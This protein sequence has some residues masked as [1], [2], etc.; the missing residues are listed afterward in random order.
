M[1]MLDFNAMAQPTWSVKLK[2]PDQTVVNV[3]APTVEMYD[4]LI[5]LTPELNSVAK[6]KDGKTIR[7]V[8]SLAAELM[9]FNEDGFEFTAE[10][11]RDKYRLTL[12]DVIRFIAG[13]LEFQKE[14]TEAKN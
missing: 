2:D 3:S 5:A 10:E 9:N 12:V 13:Y 4:R 11:L 1:Q 6:K 8:Y 7:A 14:I